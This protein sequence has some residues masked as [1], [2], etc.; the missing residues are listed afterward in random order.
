MAYYDEQG[1]LYLQNRATEVINH[2][3]RQV[4]LPLKR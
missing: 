4:I 2:K 3:T 1:Y